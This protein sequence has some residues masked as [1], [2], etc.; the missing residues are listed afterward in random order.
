MNS[1]VYFEFNKTILIKLKI[2]NY[3]SLDKKKDLKSKLNELSDAISK[4]IYF[5]TPIQG[6]KDFQDMEKIHDTS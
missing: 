1:K 3:I 4:S 5:H 2:Y 6:I